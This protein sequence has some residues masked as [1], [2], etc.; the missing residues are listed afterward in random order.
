[1]AFAGTLA[2]GCIYV[3][4]MLGVHIYYMAFGWDACSREAYM[5]AHTQ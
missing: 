4:D 1:M 5:S 3:G 2:A